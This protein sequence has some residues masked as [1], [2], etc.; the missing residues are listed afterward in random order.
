MSECSS[1]GIS[2]EKRCSSAPV[3][4]DVHMGF[5]MHDTSTDGE[6]KQNLLDA[7]YAAL[8]NRA[9]TPPANAL[10]DHLLMVVTGEASGSSRGSYAKTKKQHRLAIEGF[11][12]DLLRAQNHGKGKGWVFRSL[13]AQSFSGEDI[14]Y[15]AFKHVLEKLVALD[16]V[17]HKPAV[18]TFGDGFTPGGP[19]LVYWRKASRFMAT[20]ALLELSARYGV[21][22]VDASAHFIMELPRHPLQLRARAT[23]TE[24]GEKVKGKVIRFDPTP[25]TEK[26]ENQVRSLNEFFDQFELRGGTH[27]GFIRIFN[28]GNDQ[29]FDWNKGGRLYRQGDDTYQQLPKED[30]LRMTINGEP[31]CEI[32]I[33]AS[34]LTIYQGWNGEQLDLD[35]DPYDLPGLGPEAREVVKR[36]FVATFGSDG[37][38][39]RWPSDFVSDYRD[40]TGRKLGKDYPLKLIR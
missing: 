14:G 34:Y 8:A 29:D 1:R 4:P 30:R 27:R 28:N 10:V 18:H 7:R 33:R 37:H 25:E 38:L 22:V 26:L 6:L 20:E 9:R 5:H 15:R 39:T 32:D 40:Q 16:L 12:G 21:A 3:F 31:V 19:Q 24:Y 23:R 36:W 13:A 17:I 2:A 35:Q 11:V